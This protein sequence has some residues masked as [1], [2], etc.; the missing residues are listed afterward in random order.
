MKTD[1]SN[2]MGKLTGAELGRL[3][4]KDEIGIMAGISPTYSRDDFDKATAKMERTEVKKYLDCWHLSKELLIMCW[5][6]WWSQAMLRKYVLHLD[7]F[8]SFEILFEL[9]DDKGFELYENSKEQFNK[10][11]TLI[12]ENIVTYL[13]SYEL[14]KET[15]NRFGLPELEVIAGDISDVEEIINIVNELR[16]IK[17]YDN[18]FQAIDI[19]ELKK[20]KQ[21]DVK[22]KVDSLMTWLD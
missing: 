15:A 1:I 6:H 10:L 7:R 14:L 12:T 4:L 2:V 13:N 16:E 9:L 21:L 20:V 11:Q 22:E 19:E 8:R 5:I 17:P 18:L 3:F